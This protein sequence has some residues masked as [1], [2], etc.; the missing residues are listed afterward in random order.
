MFSVITNIYNKKT[1]GPTLMKLFTATEKLKKF[2]LTTRDVRCV[3]HGWRC[4]H[5]GWQCTHR[6]D[7]HVVASHA[8][9]WWRVCDNNLNIVSMCALSPVVCTSNISSCQ[10]NL[11][12]FSCGCEKFHLGRSFGFLVIN[13]CNHG[14]HYETPCILVHT[15]SSFCLFLQNL[16]INVFKIFNY[17]G[18]KI[19]YWGT[20]FDLREEETGYKKMG[21]SY[22]RY[23]A[24]A[25]V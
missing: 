23:Q 17:S 15:L 12:H 22:V 25:V 19:N 6:Y 5:H 14:E 20:H 21:A 9:R 1:E 3:H 4:A 2:F 13:V 18:S 16:K 7:I 8:S 24:S 11:F 10:K